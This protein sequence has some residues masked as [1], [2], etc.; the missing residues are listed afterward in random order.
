MTDRAKLPHGTLGSPGIFGGTEVG[1]TK[2]Y[3]LEAE[4]KVDYNESGSL[5]PIGLHPG[6]TVS[7]FWK[8]VIIAGLACGALSGVCYSGYRYWFPYGSSH[9]CDKLLYLELFE[10]AREHNGWFPRGEAGPEASLSLLYRQD[11]L[12]VDVLRGKTVPE[13]VVR[14][15][16]ERGELLGPE[17]CGWHYVEGLRIDDDHHLALFWD[18]IGLGHN[19]Q[20]LE[21]GGHYVCFL[22]GIEYVP[23][24]EWPAFLAE[25]ERLLA[26]L[27]RPK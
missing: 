6:A 4:T 26:K 13:S 25:Q 22:R 15:I 18:K 23:E 19:G 27:R 2:R 12:L 5:K 11:P 9:C 21:N 24:S 14:S 8:C 17:T 16:L 1:A 10:Y 3:L 20:R 7:R